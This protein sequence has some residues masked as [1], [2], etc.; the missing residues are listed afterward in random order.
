MKILAISYCTAD[1]EYSP[2]NRL[3]KE[4]FFCP[5]RLE[6]RTRE[7]RRYETPAAQMYTGNGHLHLMNGVRDL[8]HT[9]GQGIVDVRIIS[10]GFGLLKEED[11]IVPYTYT[12]HRQGRGEIRQRS[13]ELGIHPIIKRLIPSY[14]LVFFLLSNDYVTACELPFRV[15]NSATQIFLVA[16]SLEYTIRANG[17]YIHAVCAGD[18]LIDSL[19]GANKYNLKGF[20]FER[21]CAVACE[22]GHQ[23]F[24]QVKTNPQ[25]IIDMVLDCN[26]EL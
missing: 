6:R 24:E 26:R 25:R 16:P 7:L 18:E 11:P 22:Q 19:D 12:F 14:D 1:K 9:F 8:R 10:P 15:P 17:L 2:S 13:R 20:V 21:L 23:V 5:E 4:D 3:M